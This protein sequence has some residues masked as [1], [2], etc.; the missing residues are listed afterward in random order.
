MSVLAGRMARDKSMECSGNFK[1]DADGE[2]EVLE[3]NENVAG[4]SGAGNKLTKQYSR[5]SCYESEEDDQN[6]AENDESKNADDFVVG[7]LVPLKEQIE[8]D[9]EDESLTR[10]KEQLL[11]AVDINSIGECLEPEVKIESISIVTAGRPEVVLPV[12]FSPNPK[13]Y[14]FAL[15][16]GSRYNLKVTFSVHNN[17]VSGLRYRNTVWKSGVRVDRSRAMLGTFSPQRDPYTFMMEEETTPSG[18]LARGSYSAKTKFI[19]DDKRCYLKMNYTFEIRKD[20]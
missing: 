15:K 13:G 14:S 3:G 19:D 11:G 9:K 7:P 16:E 8:K 20:W 18:F 10:W 1:A 4:S 17:I 6:S 5:S 12:P 2:E